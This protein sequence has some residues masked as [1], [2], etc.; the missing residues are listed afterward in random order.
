V[1]GV[2][3]GGKENEERKYWGEEKPRGIDPFQRKCIG[4]GKRDQTEGEWILEIGGE[5]ESKKGG[6]GG[7]RGGCLVSTGYCPDAK[8]GGTRPLL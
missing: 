7:G 8:K 3:Y 2:T 1:K 6:G 5:Q 4:P